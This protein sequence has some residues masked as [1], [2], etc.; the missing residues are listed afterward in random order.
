[1][2]KRTKVFR[3]IV[4]YSTGRKETVRVRPTKIY[5]VDTLDRKYSRETGNRVKGE[6]GWLNIPMLHLEQDSA[7]LVDYPFVGKVGSVQ[8][9]GSKKPGPKREIKLRETKLFYIDE[10]GR[11]F[12]K[13]EGGYSVCEKFRLDLSSVQER[14]RLKREY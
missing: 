6:D 12:R 2:H 4:T 10:G 5:Y 13:N 11:K 14:D 3:G 8:T 7:Y 1:M 9:Q